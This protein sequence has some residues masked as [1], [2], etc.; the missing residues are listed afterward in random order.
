MKDLKLGVDNISADFLDKLDEEVKSIIVKA[1]QRAK[2]NNR[3][4]VMGRDV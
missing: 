1:C 4:T 3:R 2:E